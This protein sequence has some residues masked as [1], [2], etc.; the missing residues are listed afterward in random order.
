MFK[1][2]LTIIYSIIKYNT[3]YKTNQ[4]CWDEVT[5]EF[6]ESKRRTKICVELFG[7]ENLIGLSDAQRNK[8]WE[9]I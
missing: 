3:M 4:Q 8:F 1:Q 7:Q 9:S 5:N 6:I 2:E